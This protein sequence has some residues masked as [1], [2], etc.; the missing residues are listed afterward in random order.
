M[1]DSF[2]SAARIL[3]VDD[4]KDITTVLKMLLDDSGYRTQSF[5][6]AK[7][8]LAAFTPGTYQIALIDLRMRDMDGMELSKKLV[9]A[10][11]ALKVCFMTAY[12]WHSIP[13]SQRMTESTIQE[14]QYIRKPFSAMHLLTTIRELLEGESSN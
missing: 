14:N 13:L 7:E 10:D 9:S 2:P 5:E 8:A 6:S 4:E 3:I 11:P 1:S 12:D